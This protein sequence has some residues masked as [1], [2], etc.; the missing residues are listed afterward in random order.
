MEECSAKRTDKVASPSCASESE[1]GVG[2]MKPIPER[3]EETNNRFVYGVTCGGEWNNE[4]R[5]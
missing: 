5:I 2:S 3:L 1:R 4:R